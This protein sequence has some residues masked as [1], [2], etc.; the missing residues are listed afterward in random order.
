MKDF[1]KFTLSESPSVT[2][3]SD[4]PSDIDSDEEEIEEGKLLPR[5][6]KKLAKSPTIC[7]PHFEHVVCINTIK[8]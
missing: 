8:M 1:I 7:Y 5:I 6:Q 4:E 2:I 3:E